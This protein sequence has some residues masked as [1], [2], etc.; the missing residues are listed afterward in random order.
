M[1]L[2][3]NIV[4]LK[5]CVSMGDHRDISRWKI[6]IG[7]HYV[8]HVAPDLENDNDLAAALDAA[9]KRF[10]DLL[11]LLGIDGDDIKSC[12]RFVKANYWLHRPSIPD[13]TDLPAGFDTS[14]S[15]RLA[16]GWVGS[17]GI[18]FG[19]Q[20]IPWLDRVDSMT[21]EE[22]HHIWCQQVGEAPSLL[23]EGI[24]VWYETRL[25]QD[26]ERRDELRQQWN[27]TVNAGVITLT[28]LCNT[29]D[30]W[31]AYR[32]GTPVYGVAGAFTGFL[33][34]QHGLDRLRKL[35]LATHYEDPGLAKLLEDMTGVTLDQ[36]ASNVTL[37][38]DGTP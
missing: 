17:D 10:S 37:W 33:I 4:D 34:H 7:T 9:D 8:F 19:V 1:R 29:S 3:V 5:R 23:N 2:V 31:N 12:E 21:H 25:S 35:F 24:A 14:S 36:L 27:N 20:N 30:F 6:R 26:L 16:H 28:E 18:H 22:I 15:A 38:L 13:S 11:N 32:A